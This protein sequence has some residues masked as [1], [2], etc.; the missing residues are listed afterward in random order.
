MTESIK[1]IY[2]EIT[3]LF[4]NITNNYLGSSFTDSTL[5]QIEYSINQRLIS[6]YP[7]YEFNPIIKFDQYN[8]SVSINV[9]PNFSGF[10]KISHK[11]YYTHSFIENKA[12][13]SYYKIPTLTCEKCTL[14]ISDNGHLM[15]GDFSCDEYIIKNMLE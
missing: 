9:N 3:T 12:E 5:K 8:R 11:N 6:R 1:E 10:P 4:S 14:S 13:D 7:Y 15:E 2:N